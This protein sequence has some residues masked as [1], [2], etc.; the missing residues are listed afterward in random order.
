VK[1]VSRAGAAHWDDR[2]QTIG[3]ES[4]SWYEAEPSTSIDLLDAV[5]ATHGDAVIDVGGGASRLV[6]HLISLG[7]QDSTV[8]D[9]SK[10]ALDVARNRVGS[11][12]PV[13]WLTGDIL[14]WRPTRHYDIWHDRAV[15]HFLTTDRDRARYV[16][17]LRSAIRPGGAVIIGVFAQDGPAQCSGLQV[18]R[19]TPAELRS[20]LPDLALIE[21]RR[22]EHRTPNGAVQP[23]NW[24][25]GRLP[26]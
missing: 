22:H 18:R 9:L 4:V 3:P 15:L 25:A 8:F 1:A 14:D 5:G 2:Y 6:D 26:G 20:L 7:Y 13:T 12:A 10:A 16:E 11:S 21:A 17:T 19:Y 24:I 23:F